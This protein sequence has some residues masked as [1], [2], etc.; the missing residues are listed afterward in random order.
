MDVFLSIEYFKK[1]VVWGVVPW[2]DKYLAEKAKR[3]G[4]FLFDNLEEAKKYRYFL[5]DYSS[6]GGH[7]NILSVPTNVDSFWK[8]I[9]SE[10]HYG[11]YCWVEFGG[12]KPNDPLKGLMNRDVRFLESDVFERGEHIF[13]FSHDAQYLYEILRQ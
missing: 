13:T 7:L 3:Y 12:G 11:E 9:K 6:G 4:F 10:G 5:E 2:F 1:T 8:V